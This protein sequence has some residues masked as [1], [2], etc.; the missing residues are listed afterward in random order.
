[1]AQQETV[2]NMLRDLDVAQGNVNEN[3]DNAGM[4]NKFITVAQETAK[5]L[6]KTYP[7]FWHTPGKKATGWAAKDLSK[8]LE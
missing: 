1:M 5:N 3:P 4:M 6:K 8:D 2:Q 7:D